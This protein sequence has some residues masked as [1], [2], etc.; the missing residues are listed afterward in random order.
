MD[1]ADGRLER[2]MSFKGRNIVSSV[3][4]VLFK[5]GLK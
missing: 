3:G 1:G 4:V 2:E 5:V